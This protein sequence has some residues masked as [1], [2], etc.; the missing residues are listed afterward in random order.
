ML[1]ASTSRPVLDLVLVH[2]SFVCAYLPTEQHLPVT[3]PVHGSDMCLVLIRVVR[4]L[5]LEQSASVA[6]PGSIPRN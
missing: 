3:V 4:Q 5:P 6:A 1:G 2:L